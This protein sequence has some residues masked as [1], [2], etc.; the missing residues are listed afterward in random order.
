MPSGMLFFCV[1]TFYKSDAIKYDSREVERI[2]EEA[3]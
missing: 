3:E 2:I 1:E